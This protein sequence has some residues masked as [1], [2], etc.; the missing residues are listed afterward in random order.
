[1]AHPYDLTDRQVQILTLL[2]DDRTSGQICRELH[3]THHTLKSHLYRAGKRMGCGSRAA[4]VAL[5]Y[6]SGVLRI[7]DVEL[8]RQA[9]EL[10]QRVREQRVAAMRADLARQQRAGGAAA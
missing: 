6:R 7:P 2:A 10:V 9:D 1:M 5:A 8:M 3:I 4:M